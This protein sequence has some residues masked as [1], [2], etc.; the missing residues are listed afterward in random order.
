MKIVWDEPKRLTNIRIHRYDFD[1]LMDFDWDRAVVRA[2]K[3]GPHGEKRF[4]AVGPLEETMI[5]IVFSLLGREAMSVISMRPA[6]RSERRR[7][8]REQEANH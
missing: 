4:M 1:Q 5:A 3:D 7:Y 8:A 6:S 2:A